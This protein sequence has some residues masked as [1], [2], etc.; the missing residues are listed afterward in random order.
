M[1]FKHDVLR[2][3]LVYILQL[4]GQPGATRGSNPEAHTHATAA[5]SKIAGDVAGGRFGKGDGHIS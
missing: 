1:A 4:V 3:E 5:L 2:A